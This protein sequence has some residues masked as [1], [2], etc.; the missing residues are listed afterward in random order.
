MHRQLFFK[1][2]V[3][4]L[5]YIPL[6]NLYFSQD[7]KSKVDLRVLYKTMCIFT[8]AILLDETLQKIYITEPIGKC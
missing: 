6:L 1:R 7:L 5:L 2:L 3:I 8:Q 4:N